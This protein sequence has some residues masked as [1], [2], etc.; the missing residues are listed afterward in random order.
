MTRAQ[1]FALIESHGG[2]PRPSVTKA[3][4]A[5]IVGELGWPLLADGRPSRSLGKAKAYGIP[6]I[7][8][9]RFLIW[10]G[11]ASLD[12]QTK[13]YTKD[14]LATLAKVS[15]DLIDQFE[16]FGLLEPQGGLYGFR[17]LAAAR[18]IAK[19]LASN[20]K[21]STIAQS[22]AEIRRWLPEAGLANLR[23]SLDGP[24]LLLIEHAQGLV[25]KRGQFVLPMQRAAPDA[26]TLFSKAQAA[27]EAQDWENAERLYTLVMK[28]DPKDAAAAFN[29]AN[30][31]RAQ[32][33][34]IEAEAAYR[35]AAGRDPQFAEAWYNLAHLLDGQRRG[36]EAIACLE[37][38][39]AA[40]PDYADAVFN[41]AFLLHRLERP[42]EAA[43]CWQRYLKLDRV[44]AWADRAKR[45]LKLCEMQI[46]CP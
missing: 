16:I 41:L 3:D 23:L 20:V 6:V 33:K 2:T 35:T 40:E 13:A 28:L 34:F 36:A 44:S 24:D 8:E 31:L 26:D 39:I 14:Q 42:A 15:S 4:S 1:A 30:L 10:T 25:D 17:D 11:K 5:L 22:L 46:A 38:A 27:E 7:S 29:L 12:T 45:A 21:L 9:R 18:Q 32:N 19:L 37:K 43:A